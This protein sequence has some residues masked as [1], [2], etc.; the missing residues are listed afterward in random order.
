[1]SN[2]VQHANPD[3]VI[4]RYRPSPL[5]LEVTDDGSGFAL[6]PDLGVLRRNG[7]FGVV[8]IAERVALIGGRMSV[9]SGPGGG[10][11]LSVKR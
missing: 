11:R 6:P 10:T 7:H 8:G 4:L 5:H 9:V 2:A 3:I 1:M